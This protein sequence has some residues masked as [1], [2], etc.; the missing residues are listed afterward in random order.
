MYGCLIWIG[1]IR[2]GVADL[3]EITDKR[4]SA[5]AGDVSMILAGVSHKTF[6]TR[7]ALFSNYTLLVTDIALP[8]RT[9]WLQCSFLGLR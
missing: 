9:V 5:E 3:D 8:E 4:G 6:D 1:T 2:F 7:P